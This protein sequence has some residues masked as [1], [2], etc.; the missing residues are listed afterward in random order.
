MQRFILFLDLQE[1]P[2]LIK[3][4]EKIHQSIPEEIQKSIFSSGIETMNLFRFEDRLCMEILAND[5]FSFAQKEDMDANNPTV[6][7]WENLMFKYQKII[8][9]TP[10]G[11]KWVLAKNIFSLSK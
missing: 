9:G 2:D 7:V 1:D 6:Q 10:E 8:P 4:Y 11:V 5:S 3:E